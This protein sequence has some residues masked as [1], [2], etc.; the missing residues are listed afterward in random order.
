MIR[1]L[2]LLFALRLHLPS[3]FAHEPEAQQPFDLGHAHDALSGHFHA[4]WESRYFAQGRDS[5]GGDSLAVFSAEISWHHLSAGLW[6]GFSPEQTYD[7][8]KFILACTES[9]GDFEYYLGCTHLWFPYADTE[10]NELGAGV[11]WSGLPFEME[12]AID[13]SYS[14]AAS[15]TFVEVGLSRE[16]QVSEA[17]SL[18]P[19]GV[20]GLNHGFISDG[21]DGANHFGLRLGARYALSESMALTGH[22]AYSWALNHQPDYAGDQ[23][24]IDMFH[25][26]IGIEWT[27]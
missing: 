6:H 10:D 8:T 19:S 21:H 7:E 9:L 16:F 26:S 14:F 15:G 5:L 4:G 12:V 18:T 22:A 24:L 13:G 23:N 20:L 2:L 25:A 3:A 11:T 27:F 1:P 17:L